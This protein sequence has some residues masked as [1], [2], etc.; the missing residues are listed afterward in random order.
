[1]DHLCCFCLFLLCFHARPFIDA[2]WL[3]AGKG[4][5]YWLSFVISKSKKKGKDQK[6]IQSSTTPDSGHQ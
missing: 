2:L 3:T 4:L 1:M 6:S 5:T